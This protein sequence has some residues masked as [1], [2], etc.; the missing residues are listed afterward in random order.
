MV[1]NGMKALRC[2]IGHGPM[3]RLQNRPEGGLFSLWLCESCGDL[4]LR[5]ELR[6]DIYWFKT[7][8]IDRM[9]RRMM[10]KAT[11]GFHTSE[12]VLAEF[13]CSCGNPD[14]PHMCDDCHA[15]AEES[16]M[17]QL[18]GDPGEVAAEKAQSEAYEG[19]DQPW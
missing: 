4:A 9:G 15:A 18:E 10:H 14:G 13:A 8:V 7:A 5:M 3:L 16:K 12:S 6:G 19:D 17:I 11:C 2:A 1:D